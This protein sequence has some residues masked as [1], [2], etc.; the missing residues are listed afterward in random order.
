MDACSRLGRTTGVRWGCAPPPC[1]G[2]RP[3]SQAVLPILV[4]QQR[5]SQCWRGGLD[6]KLSC[7]ASKP[8][9]GCC[10]SMNLCCAAPAG[11]SAVRPPTLQLTM[12]V[13]YL[14][15]IS[16]Q[17]GCWFR[18]RRRV[19]LHVML[20]KEVSAR[21]RPIG[22]IG[23]KLW[24]HA[25]WSSQKLEALQETWRQIVIP[26]KHHGMAHVETLLDYRCCRR[27]RSTPSSTTVYAF[28]HGLSE[29][30]GEATHPA[31]R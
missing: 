16:A 25:K 6:L 28:M 23:L 22:A 30:F 12:H 26:A 18:G 8:R 5:H 14:K 31:C 21:W 9:D 17:C 29:N 20:A 11:L 7:L 19:L 15:H 13:L 4:N 1:C 27:R 3:L 10:L 24:R 2:W